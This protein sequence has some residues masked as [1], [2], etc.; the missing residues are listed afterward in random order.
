MG[1]H[2]KSSRFSLLLRVRP[3]EGRT[4]RLDE[5]RIPGAAWRRQSAAPV[6]VALGRPDD[7]TLRRFL[8]ALRSWQLEE[9]DEPIRITRET[10]HRTT[11]YVLSRHFDTESDEDTGHTLSVLRGFLLALAETAERDF[12]MGRI[13]LR[14]LVGRARSLTAEQQPPSKS[15]VRRAATTARDLMILLDQEGWQELPREMAS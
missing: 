4:D 14:E 6:S 10:V 2:A 7:E 8:E 3:R 15:N 1:R 12:D 5:H 11:E 9:S 13:V